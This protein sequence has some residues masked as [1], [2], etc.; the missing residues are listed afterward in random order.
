MLFQ[1]LPGGFKL[2]ALLF[3]Q[4]LSGVPEG[5]LEEAGSLFLLPFAALANAFGS[6]KPG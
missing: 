2:A 4:Q 6:V 1:F 3:L 5:I